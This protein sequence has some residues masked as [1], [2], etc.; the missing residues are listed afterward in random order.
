MNNSGSQASM[1]NQGSHSTMS[2][3]RNA[4]H[5]SRSGREDSSQNAAVD[6]LNEQ[7]LQAAQQGRSFNAGGGG[8]G[9][10]GSGSGSGS[11]SSMS[12]SGGRM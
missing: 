9:M 11:D 8:S 7:S 4:R 5:A 12:G 3:S 2:G 6:R 10:S 1:D